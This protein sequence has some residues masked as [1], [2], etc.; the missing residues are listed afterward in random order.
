[1]RALA[2]RCTGVPG[3]RN[4][5]VPHPAK[6]VRRCAGAPVRLV[7]GVMLAFCLIAGMPGAGRAQNFGNYNPRDDQYRLLGMTRP[8]LAYRLKRRTAEDIM[9]GDR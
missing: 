3:H 4:R 9:Q 7:V 6:S 8:Q 5:D 1:V 2:Y